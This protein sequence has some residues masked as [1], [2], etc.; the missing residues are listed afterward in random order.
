MISARRSSDGA[1]SSEVAPYGIGR[2]LHRGPILVVGSA[3]GG[4]PVM[5]GLDVDG[6]P[7]PGDV[8]T[9][10]GVPTRGRTR[11]SID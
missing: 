2:V 6:R 10:K 5:A 11:E 8:Q 1:A 4:A 7:P 9:R 3:I